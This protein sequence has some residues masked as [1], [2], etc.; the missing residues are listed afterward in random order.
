MIYSFALS[1]FCYQSGVTTIKSILLFT[2]PAAL[3]TV[4]RAPLSARNPPGVGDDGVWKLILIGGGGGGTT[5]VISTKSSLLLVAPVALVIVSLPSAT[6]TVLVPSKKRCP[7][8]GVP[9][10]VCTPSTF[11]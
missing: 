5:G 7:L 8:V 11:T 10:T 9:L 2:D 1:P 3:V 6:V 4:N